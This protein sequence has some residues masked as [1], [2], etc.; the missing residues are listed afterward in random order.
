[1]RTF[2]DDQS[3]GRARCSRN[4]V[5]CPAYLGRKGPVACLYMVQRT[6]VA[7]RP[8]ARFSVNVRPAQIREAIRSSAK[9]I[10]Q[11]KS[12]CR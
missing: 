1:M 12:R 10:R 6:G 11:E 4:T 9:A 3:T 7:V 8:V 5:R 2:R